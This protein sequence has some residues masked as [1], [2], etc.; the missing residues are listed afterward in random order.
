MR[1]FE[2]NSL[3]VGDHVLVHDDLDPALQLSDGVV[4]VVETRQRL[5]NDVGI[6]V[7]PRGA[8]VRRPRRH[9]VHLAPVDRREDCWRCD[10]TA[11]APAG[12]P[13]GEP[14]RG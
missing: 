14:V 10:A 3:R 5:A 13:A 4:T 7:G 2:W 1:I 9:A 8:S 12:A 6:R 11:G